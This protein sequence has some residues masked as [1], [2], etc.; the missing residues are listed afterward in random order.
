MPANL[1]A[2]LAMPA[3]RRDSVL[4]S[5][6]AIFPGGETVIVIGSGLG[7]ITASDITLGTAKAAAITRQNACRVDFTNPTAN[8]FPTGSLTIATMPPL[9]MPVCCATPTIS[10]IAPSHGRPTEE[11]TI[12]GCGFTGVI[13]S[14][15]LQPGSS[16]IQKNC[17]RSANCLSDNRHN[18]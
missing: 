11:I 12:I 2:N 7:R 10:A 14:L 13:V 5:R 8:N 17:A 6:P 4:L 16:P 9:Q 15:V 1:A 18:I 3:I